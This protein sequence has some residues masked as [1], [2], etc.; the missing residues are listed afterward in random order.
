MRGLSYQA[1][2]VG[3]V[4]AISLAGPACAAESR[5]LHTVFEYEGQKRD[6]I[7][8]SEP[9][10]GKA[11]IGQR[12]GVDHEVDWKPNKTS[13]AFAED[14]LPDGSWIINK[15]IRAVIVEHGVWRIQDGQICTRVTQSPFGTKGRQEACRQVWRDRAS[16]KIAMIDAQTTFRVVL[17][18]SSSPLK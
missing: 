7:P 2:L 1:G 13:I 15:A 3:L 16:G 4:S 5:P 12:L 9:E 8:L 17:I 14:F 10:I 18:F 6:L 11:L